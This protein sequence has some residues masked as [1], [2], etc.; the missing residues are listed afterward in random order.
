MG[1]APKHVPVHPSKQ[2][3]AMT[4]PVF[5]SAPGS[6]DPEPEEAAVYTLDIIVQLSGVPRETVRA[7][8]QEGL[9]SPAQDPDADSPC[10]DDEALRTLRRIEHLKADYG[11][12][13]PGIRLMLHLLAETERLEAELRAQR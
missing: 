13:L 7:Y 1:E 12:S 2:R 4:I 10:F 5:N 9:I 11:M 8:Q 3:L 6:R